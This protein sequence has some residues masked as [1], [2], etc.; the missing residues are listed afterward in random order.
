MVSGTV[1]FHPIAGNICCYQLPQIAKLILLFSVSQP[2]EL[3]VHGFCHFR[4]IVLVMTPFTVELSVWMGMSGCKC[5][6]SA[7]VAQTATA[8]FALMKRV[9][10]STLVVE[11][12]MALITFVMLWLCH[13]CGGIF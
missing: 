13:Y 2:I 3:H 7:T 4:G 12:M 8:C 11:N 1:V 5:P 6:I 9:T 10:N